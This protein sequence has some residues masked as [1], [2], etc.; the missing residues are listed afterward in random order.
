VS[1]DTHFFDM[2]VRKNSVSIRYEGTVLKDVMT[3]FRLCGVIAA[4]ILG[5]LCAAQLSAQAAPSTDRAPEKKQEVTSSS[6]TIPNASP[7]KEPVQTGIDRPAILVPAD[8]DE[9][10]TKIL[11]RGLKSQPVAGDLETGL[12]IASSQPTFLV[13][14]G[15]TLVGDPVAAESGEYLTQL[16][17][18]G[19]VVFGDSSA[20]LLYKGRQVEVLRFSKPGLVAKPPIGDSFIAREDQSFSILLENPST[21]SYSSVRAR[22]RFDD[23]DVCL[24]SAEEFGEKSAEPSAQGSCDVNSDWTEFKIPQF[25][26]TSLKAIPSSTWFVDPNT[27]YAKSAKRKG[28]LT[29]RFKNEHSTQIEEQNLPI[30]VQ[31]EPG[32]LSL[33]SSLAK[34]A[35]L[36]LVGAL[37]SLFLRVSVP[38]IK[39][40][41][42]LKD[43]LRD[44]GKII[45]TVSTEVDSN[46]RVLLRVERRALDELRV[47]VWS[48]GPGY[49]DYAKRVEQALPILNRRIE[50][51]LRLDAAL[52]R[53]KTL[54]EQTAAPT[55]LEQ[56][57]EMLSVA[58]EILKQDQ[59]SDEEWVCVNQRLDSALKLLREPTP[60]EKEAFEAML[61]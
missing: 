2:L 20:P 33:L 38:N 37:L 60:T 23:Q 25:A 7:G 24:F 3:P 39:R 31:F 40:R 11:L 57:E 32:R 12:L 55:R 21:F 52:T 13:R 19:L 30:E 29:L 44:A 17:I 1:I 46:L 50:A 42:V 48:F 51:V 6:G 59:L 58:S 15:V 8:S 54:T 56:I 35:A 53:K 14:P 34:V 22:L 61:S 41:S 47:A 36:L 10:T 4:T 16:R 5:V 43:Q 28:W 18:D 9:V 49:A 27:N 26:Q 45:S